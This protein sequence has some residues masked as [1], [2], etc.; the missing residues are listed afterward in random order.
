MDNLLIT[1]KDPLHGEVVI[2]GAK[3]A[4]L[5]VIIA[6]ASD[7][8]TSIDRISRPDRGYTNIELKPAGPGANIR[9]I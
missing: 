2:A 1:G 9:L 3:N 4:A 8:E 7:G 5:P 6:L